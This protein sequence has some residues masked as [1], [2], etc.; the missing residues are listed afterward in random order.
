MCLFAGLGACPAAGAPT[1]AGAVLFF[2]FQRR[3]A[4]GGAAHQD[5]TLP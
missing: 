5:T 4:G 3:D 2:S 1:A